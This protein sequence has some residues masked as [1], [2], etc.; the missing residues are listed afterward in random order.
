MPARLPHALWRC[1]PRRFPPRLRATRS[2]DR[3]PP[4]P[5]QRLRQRMLRR[6]C[7][8]PRRSSRTSPMQYRAV[9]AAAAPPVLGRSA[10]ADPEARTR[11][12]AVSDE[13]TPTPVEELDD[14]LA[15]ES[16]EPEGIDEE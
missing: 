15:T 14:E 16:A 5:S 13:A 8:L 1:G 9:R 6:I 7:G 3:A 12:E 11:L 4:W 10:T 2:A